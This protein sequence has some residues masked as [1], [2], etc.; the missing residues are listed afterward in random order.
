MDIGTADK[1]RLRKMDHALKSALSI[2]LKARPEIYDHILNAEA[3]WLRNHSD[4]L[5]SGRQWVRMVY[6]WFG[7]EN[8][9]DDEAIMNEIESLKPVRGVQPYY[10]TFQR[11]VARLKTK[12]KDDPSC[13]RSNKLRKAF[14]NAVGNF[15]EMVA[16]AGE[17]GYMEDK[18]P[19][20]TYSALLRRV[21]TALTRQRTTENENIRNINKVFNKRFQ[22]QPLY[23]MLYPRS[24]EF[25]QQHHNKRRT[26]KQPMAGMTRLS[27][28]RN[29]KDGDSK[30]SAKITKSENAFSP[31]CRRVAT[32]DMENRN[33]SKR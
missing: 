32:L 9:D 18:N 20:Y 17:Y 11:H 14:L 16:I 30:E 31:I 22:E 28:K 27:G 3:E 12:P 4:I 25:L 21:T 5:M 33:P 8:G 15:P 13:A 6:D 7:N 23:S 19:Q 26:T 2:K 24:K 1:G 10:D 29:A